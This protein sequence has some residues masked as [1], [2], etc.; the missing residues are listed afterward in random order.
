MAVGTARQPL[1]SLRKGRWLFVYWFL[2]AYFAAGVTFARDTKMTS[3]PQP[4]LVL[5]VGALLIALL[6]GFRYHVGGDWNPYEGMFRYAGFIDLEEVLIRK[7]PGYQ[8]LNWLV[9][10]VGGEIW[11]VNL[12]CGSVF[13]WGLFRFAKTQPN[14]WLT[15]L[16][17]IPYLVVVVAM[18]YTRQAVAIGFLMG[19]L[20]AMSRG[21]T[22]LRFA[23]YILAAALF[24]KTAVVGL[25]LV[26][27]ASRRNRVLNTIALIATFTL[28]YDLFLDDS[29]DMFVENYIEAQYSS[30]GAAIRIAMSIIPAV[31][32]LL[33]PNR[34]GFSQRDEQIWRN[35]SFAA[36]ALLVLLFT[37]PSSTVVDRLALYIIPLQLVI[38]SRVPRAYNSEVVGKVAVVAYCFV[39][40]FAW[41]NYA[42]HAEYW[43]PYSFYPLG[44]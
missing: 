17:A 44:I 4:R 20:A 35:F 16:I 9:H 22:T 19:G 11:L 12:V 25:L 3:R 28:F 41:L 6:V 30:Q 36:L 10:W 37:L 14:P 32:F 7:D 24:H 34:F 39:V 29:V 2:F 31:L 33:S 21:A 1:P 42:S 8:L 5:G 43:I 38:L 15:M 13:G 18:G 27:F 26:A 40:Q 23:A